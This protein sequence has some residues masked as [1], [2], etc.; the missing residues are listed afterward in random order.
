M[1]ESELIDETLEYF[2]NRMGN[3]WHWSEDGE[4]I[5]WQTGKTLCYTADLLSILRGCSN[6]PMP[7][8]G[9]ILLVV[10]ACSDNWEPVM[11][12][13]IVN[14]QTKLIDWYEEH[15]EIEE[16]DMI[17]HNAFETLAIVRSLDK[18]VR[19]GAMR[20]PLIRAVFEN[21]WSFHTAFDN[22][23]PFLK[24]WIDWSE[25]KEERV[26]LIRYLTNPD[27]MEQ[28]PVFLLKEL[29]ALQSS[30]W[31]KTGTKAL[32]EYLLTN[33]TDTPKPAE[34][35]PLPEPITTPLTLIEELL[36][37]DKTEGLAQLT[38]RLLAAIKI[39]SQT[40]GSSDQPF[41]GFS[42]ITNRGNLD[43]L[44]I[45]ELAQD[46]DTL[47]ARLVNNEAMYLRREEPPSDIER[48]RTI[49]LDT[50]IQMWGLPRVFAL[51]AA[52]AC[53]EKKQNISRIDAFA[54]RGE[55]LD[56]L[57]LTTKDGV[58]Q[59]LGKLDG[60]LHC[61][62]A[63]RDFLRHNRSTESHD[64][65]F[66]TDADALKTPA[67]QVYFAEIKA[68]L[69]YLIVVNRVGELQVLDISGGRSKSL[70]TSKMDLNHLLF[71]KHDPSK[72]TKKSLFTPAFYNEAELPLFYLMTNARVSRMHTLQ[73]PSVG[74]VNITQ[75]QRVLRVSSADLG[76]TELLPFIEEGEYCMGFGSIA[77]VYILVSNEQT[78]L[79]KLYKIHMDKGLSETHDFTGR[80]FAT[81]DEM[82]FYKSSF[83]L[84]SNKIINCFTG[85]LEEGIGFEGILG[86][87]RQ[88]KEAI[89][90][91]QIK[92][93]LNNRNSP[94][95]HP[96][97]IFINDKGQLTID[98]FSLVLVNSNVLLFRQTSEQYHE[99]ETDRDEPLHVS[100]P[101]ENPNI[102]C[103]EKKWADGSLASVD[104]HGFL[105]LKSSNKS[106]PEVT[107]VL[108]FAND[109]S[110]WV[111]DDSIFG[112]TY[113]NNTTKNTEE[114]PP[115]YF[116][117]TYIQR[118]IN[119]ILQPMGLPF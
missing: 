54:L 75:N 76:A 104:T 28:Q 16:V 70:G 57:D 114:L 93:F 40:R 112:S 37:D 51:A 83:F 23:E 47:T 20:I 19:S 66:I 12:R 100:T 91:K 4:V 38:Q 98:R 10:A 18:D 80:V 49:L 1:K 87:Y 95:H 105:H 84:K 14:R 32:E 103:Y 59:A 90:L 5:E 33:L 110:A 92:K 111:S 24:H 72:R 116:Y 118:F 17:L 62:I 106:I 85:T 2:G 119:H 56:D 88:V 89:D 74:V 35:A 115:S 60:H 108:T 53:A 3:F 9:A 101:F 6:Q 34:I 78:R 69:T 58:I 71:P 55:R 63:L 15:R 46:D 102:I 113:F 81:V 30:E 27:V 96:K 77:M 73:H 43:R 50:T 44:L 8:L 82:A 68:F 13:S 79:F 109:I 48:E 61:G 22:I 21:I 26:E 7:H 94:L 117:R 36:Q 67:F 45:S 86:E 97:A 42:D 29:E 41:G 25:D 64:I 11:A 99:L 31:R 107:I 52:L 65:V 39:P